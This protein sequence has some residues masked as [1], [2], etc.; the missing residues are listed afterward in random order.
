MVKYGK[1]ILTII[2]F[3]FKVVDRVN[4]TKVNVLDAYFICGA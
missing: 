4:A 2:F 1:I 3:V